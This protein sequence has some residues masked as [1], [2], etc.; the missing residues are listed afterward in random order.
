MG[1]N[2]GLTQNGQNVY[3]AQPEFNTDLTLVK[4]SGWV[5]FANP[6]PK[7]PVTVERNIN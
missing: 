7:N 3:L 6:E 2:P 4:P 1:L 5:K